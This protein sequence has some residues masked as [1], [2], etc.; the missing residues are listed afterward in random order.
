[1]DAP[2]NGAVKI[3]AERTIYAGLNVDRT[4]A[5]MEP[6]I[7]EEIRDSAIRIAIRLA[8]GEYILRGPRENVMELESLVAWATVAAE[9]EKEGY[10]LVSPEAYA[11]ANN[12]APAAVTV[13]IEQDGSLFAVVYATGDE[14]FTAVPS[15]DREEREQLGSA[16][17]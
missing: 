9:L 3:P 8:L 15:A 17:R 12:L 2:T 11:T 6:V 4:G 7:L 1:M 16:P 5:I 13:M 14:T 10:V